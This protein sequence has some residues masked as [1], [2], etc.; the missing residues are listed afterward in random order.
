MG[1]NPVPKCH[2][3]RE[4]YVEMDLA[5]QA[6]AVL[7][8]AATSIGQ[9]SV[10]VVGQLVRERLTATP[11]GQ[12]AL[13]GMDS[14]PGDDAARREAEALLREELQADP[15]LR[16][17]LSSHLTVSAAQAQQTLVVS[18]SRLH[19]NQISFGPL[20]VNNGPGARILIV[21]VV[22][23]LC[24]LIAL[25][26]YGGHRL[27]SGDDPGQSPSSGSTQQS[28][29]GAV[30]GRA[31]PPMLTAE[32]TDQALPTEDAM[33]DGW[34]LFDQ[35]VF[36][37]DDRPEGCLPDGVSFERTPQGT[38]GVAIFVLYACPSEATASAVFRQAH[39][40]LADDRGF[41]PSTPVT[42]PRAGDE[43]AAYWYTRPSDAVATARVGNVVLRL[44][45]QEYTSE[46][47]NAVLS[48]LTSRAIERIR[49]VQARKQ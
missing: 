49:T 29:G 42:I 12:A 1:T 30:D 38:G 36:S 31:G 44:W 22:L 6:V 45:M 15:G 24:G 25:A 48:D 13:D 34:V 35:D 28:S 4:R 37:S 27:I 43:S 16:Q 33:P 18:S 10:A 32:E 21:V 20:T 41:G 14:S 26:L 46:Q 17:V 8:G 47:G 23:L 2:G 40:R 5:A 11:Q 39:Q 19:G 9:E 3:N 7:T